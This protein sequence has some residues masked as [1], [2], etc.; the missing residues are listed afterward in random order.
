MSIGH[1]V[2]GDGQ[3]AVC[4]SYDFLPY[5][6]DL[7]K[8]VLCQEHKGYESHG[9]KAKKSKVVPECPICKQKVLLGTLEPDAAV[10]R[11]IDKGCPQEAQA[12]PVKERLNFC[13]FAG[14]KA[15]E[16]V[17]ILCS[18]CGNQYCIEHRYEDVHNCKKLKSEK[19][20]NGVQQQQQQRQE[21][22]QTPAPTPIPNRLYSLGY[23]NVVFKTTPD[24]PLQLKTSVFSSLMQSGTGL[25]VTVYFLQ[26]SKI[27]PAHVKLSPNMS[28]G[29]ALDTICKVT[30]YRNQNNSVGADSRLRLF[31]LKTF[32][33]L[34]TSA[35][36]SSLLV[37]L[38]PVYLAP[39]VTLPDEIMAEAM[40]YI[41]HAD[42][43]PAPVASSSSSPPP[44]TGWACRACTL[45]NPPD[46]KSC[47]VCGGKR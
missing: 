5:K 2:E 6:C 39:H 3:C 22:K 29:K 1:G 36:V 15:N 13:S 47:G 35:V 11:H 27:S 31:H 14:C 16:H 44:A 18:I 19:Q 9:C 4:R 21:Q 33:E 8:K 28:I 24:K 40:Q 38:D 41:W 43:I 10:L 23:P 42:R 46:A 12:A 26:D 45:H 32:E 20:K 37:S 25:V 17:L 30:G 7:C 34:P